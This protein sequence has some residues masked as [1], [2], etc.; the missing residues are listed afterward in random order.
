LAG[1]KKSL[2]D[3]PGGP[4]KCMHAAMQNLRTQD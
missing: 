1:A 3:P 4:S 2:G